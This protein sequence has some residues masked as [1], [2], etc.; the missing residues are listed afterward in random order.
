[1]AC[2]MYGEEVAAGIVAEA[3]RTGAWALWGALPEETRGE[4]REIVRREEKDPFFR[5][6]VRNPLAALA[7]RGEVT[8]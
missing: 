1:M 4:I 2:F 6:V 8:Q 5:Q 3:R 7:I